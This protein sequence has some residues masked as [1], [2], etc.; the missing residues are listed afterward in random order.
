VRDRHL[1]ITVEAFEN[2]ALE[3]VLFEQKTAYFENVYSMKPILKEKRVYK[4]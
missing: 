3:Q 1:V 2:I 4:Y